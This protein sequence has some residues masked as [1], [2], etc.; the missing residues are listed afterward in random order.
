MPDVKQREGFTVVNYP[1]K[2]VEAGKDLVIDAQV[3]GPSLPDSV[4]VYTDRIS[5]WNEKNPYIKMERTYG[6]TYRALVP[7]SEVSEGMF[8]YNIVTCSGKVQQTFP[9]NVES[10]PLDWDYIGNQYWET[11]V[12][13]T[14]SK[15]MLVAPVCGDGWNGVDH[16]TLPE[17]SN[18]HFLK[19]YIREEVVDRTD[20][21]S[22]GKSL[23]IKIKGD[24]ADMK[25]GFITSVGYTYKADCPE[26]VDGVVRVPLDGLQQ[27][28]T[29]L[30]PHAYPIFLKEYF[31]PTVPIPF[32]VN[33]I[34]TLEVS[35]TGQ[36]LAI[37]SAWIE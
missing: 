7:G 37:E 17:G 20:K 23:C 6:Y 33:E 18:C 11:K 34:E 25:A 4:I 36:D 30:L 3:I 19:K 1:A 26:P 28:V 32:S 10:G 22:Q 13:A 2:A 31:E 21:L 12:V 14:D 8:R 35:A 24:V 9:G 15:V 27:T 5:F 29:A 16:Y